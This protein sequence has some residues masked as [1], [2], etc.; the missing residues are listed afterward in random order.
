[1]GVT[2]QNALQPRASIYGDL[3]DKSKRMISWTRKKMEISESYVTKKK[4]DQC[5]PYV[6]MG[7]IY[8]AYLGTNVGS[9]IDKERPVLVF[10]G[11][12]R[13]IRQ[14]NLVLIIP[15]SSKIDNRPYKVIIRPEDII[16]NRDLDESSIVVQ[17]IRSISKARLTLFKGKLSEEKLREVS[18]EVLKFLFKDIPLLRGEGDAQTILADA[19]KTVIVS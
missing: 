5:M 10:Q 17:Q 19:A 16:D 6:S 2:N 3:F 13:Y 7:D 11:N 4:E 12:D 18:R 9:E 1:M 14:S 15:I 8:Y